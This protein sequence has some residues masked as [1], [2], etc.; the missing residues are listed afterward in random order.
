MENTTAEYVLAFV[1]FAVTFA[2]TL[3]LFLR[4]WRDGYW[5]KRGEDIKYQVFA[6]SGRKQQMKG[7]SHA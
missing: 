5:G 1:I 4:S 3:V 7:N 2:G 6:D